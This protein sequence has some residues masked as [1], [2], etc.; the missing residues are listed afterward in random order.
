MTTQFTELE[1]I[2]DQ[3]L[4][5]AAGGKRKVNHVPAQVI[6]GP[7]VIGTPP[8]Q[9]SMPSFPFSDSKNWPTF[10]AMPG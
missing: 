5:A 4:Q 2:N 1:F 3:G 10:P 7:I 8:S 6:Q 9:P